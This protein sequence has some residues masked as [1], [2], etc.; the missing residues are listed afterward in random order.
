MEYEEDINVKYLKSYKCGPYKTENLLFFDSFSG[1]PIVGGGNASSEILLVDSILS[2]QYAQHL[3]A[4][5][6][7]AQH[8]YAQ[9][10]YA[11]HLYAQHQYAQHQYAQHLYAQHLYAQHQYA[12]H[13]YAQHLYDMLTSVF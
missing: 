10:Q 9:H 6:L 1:Q 7:Y 8:L 5:H 12:Q 4:Q 13:L 11:Q 2:Q 3:Y